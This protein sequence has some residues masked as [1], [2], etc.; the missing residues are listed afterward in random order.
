MRVLRA[1]FVSATAREST[2]VGHESRDHHRI[3][4]NSSGATPACFVVLPAKRERQD[5]ERREKER[6]SFGDLSRRRFAFSSDFP[7]RRLSLRVDVF[8]NCTPDPSP[9]LH[10]DA[11]RIIHGWLRDTPAYHRLAFRRIHHYWK[12]SNRIVHPARAPR[13]NVE[14]RLHVR[15]R[16]ET[17]PFALD[18]TIRILMSCGDTSAHTVSGGNSYLI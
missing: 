4:W 14:F 16:L 9:V 13:A 7:S 6:S 10:G 17:L 18:P 2:V 3:P 1:A 8:A 12:R 5:P 11:E 15:C